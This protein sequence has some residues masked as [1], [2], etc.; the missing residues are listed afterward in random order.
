MSSDAKKTIAP[1]EDNKGPPR[2]KRRRISLDTGNPKCLVMKL[3][4]L[5]PDLVYT[6][7]DTGPPH[8]KTFQTSVVFNNQTFTA[9]GRT[10]KEAKKTIAELILKS[11]IQLKEPSIAN[12]FSS[13][14][15]RQIQDFSLDPSEV[16]ESSPNFYCFENTHRYKGLV[17][18]KNKSPKSA[19]QSSP[20]YHLKQFRQDIKVEITKC[21]NTAE[22]SPCSR[23]FA[24]QGKD[25]REK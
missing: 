6:F 22:G 23:M 10:K 25:C 1:V 20:L 24:A 16:V 11:L 18:P 14:E 9:E 12:Q 8:D 5:K 17:R 3:N 4:E 15:T 2:K 13:P 19:A 7:S 21:W